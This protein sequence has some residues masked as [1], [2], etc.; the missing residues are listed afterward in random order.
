MQQFKK[1][2]RYWKVF[3]FLAMLAFMVL[4]NNKLET[5]NSSTTENRTE[6]ISVCS[7]QLGLPAVATQIP[8]STE[9][10]LPIKLAAKPHYQF[11]VLV[12]NGFELYSKN[13]ITFL[14]KQFTAITPLIDISFKKAYLV[15]SKNKDIR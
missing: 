15:S 9:G 11:F 14:V 13:H 4:L 8:L 1:H 12:R 6:T 7:N 3:G 5:S 10:A 2:I